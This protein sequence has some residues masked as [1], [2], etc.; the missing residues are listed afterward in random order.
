LDHV[1]GH[2]VGSFE[3]L[4]SDINKEGVQGPKS[5]DHDFCEA[6]IHKGESH[7]GT[8]T[9]RSGP[10]LVVVEAKDFLATIEIV[11]MPQEL[12]CESVGDKFCFAVGSDNAEGCGIGGVGDGDEDQ[13]DSRTPTEDWTEDRWV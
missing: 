2:G 5:K 6:V 11:G 4:R 10:N 1:G 8:G 7:G 13:F 9:N 12:F 3:D